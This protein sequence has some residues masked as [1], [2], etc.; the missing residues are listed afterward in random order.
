MQATTEQLVCYRPRAR[1]REPGVRIPEQVLGKVRGAVGQGVRPSLVALRLEESVPS[2]LAQLLL[3]LRHIIV[4][5]G[6]CEVV[7]C[8]VFESGLVLSQGV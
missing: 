4:P 2:V 5:V 6:V 8:R 3:A 7:E 1:W